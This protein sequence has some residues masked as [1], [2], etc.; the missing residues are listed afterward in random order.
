MCLVE[1]GNIGSSNANGP[2]PFFF[3]KKRVGFAGKVG[4]AK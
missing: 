4:I 3:T 2:Y 1:S